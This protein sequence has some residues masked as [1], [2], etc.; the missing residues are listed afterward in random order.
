[1]RTRQFLLI[2]FATALAGSA[3]AWGWQDCSTSCS[4]YI[5]GKCV[6][7]TQTCTDKGTYVTPDF[8][9]IAYGR[10]NQAYG[11]SHGW[12]TRAKAESVALQKCRQHGNDCEVMVW[13][14]NQC[15]AVVVRGDTRVGYWGLGKSAGEARNVAMKECA[16][17]HGQKCEVLA[18]QCAKP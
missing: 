12:G 1:M 2:V 3:P 15:G 9:A 6:E 7:Y 11:F 8:G 14:K 10:A 18:S 13:F 16:K 4:R 17:D 5:Q